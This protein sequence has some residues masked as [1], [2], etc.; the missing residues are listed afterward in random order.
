MSP[1]ESTLVDNEWATWKDNKSR[2]LVHN[3]HVT[4]L[5]SA[6]SC[7]FIEVF[8]FIINLIDTD[9]HRFREILD[10]AMSQLILCE[11]IH[12]RKRKNVHFGLNAMLSFCHGENLSVNDITLVGRKCLKH[13]WVGGEGEEIRH[14]TSNHPFDFPQKSDIDGRQMTQTFT[15]ASH[16]S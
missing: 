13:A 15:I 16:L 5:K 3:I 8:S 7:L 10:C 11:N 4:S 14:F 1:S 6:Y 9:E 12:E 2:Q